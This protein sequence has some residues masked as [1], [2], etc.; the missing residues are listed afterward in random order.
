MKSLLILYTTILTTLTLIIVESTVFSKQAQQE[1]VDA[2]NT[3]RRGVSPLAADMREI[4]WSNCLATVAD[5]YI[6]ECRGLAPNYDRQEQAQNG[7]C[8]ASE[9]IVGESI[10]S[11][12]GTINSNT[13]PIQYWASENVNFIYPSTC[14][15]NCLGYVQLIWSTTTFVGCAFLDL[16]TVCGE[17]GARVICNFAEGTRSG[18]PYIE[19]IACSNCTPPWSYCNN[20]LCT[21]SPT[22]TTPTISAM[23]AT[24]LATNSA[25]APII[26]ATSEPTVETTP[27]SNAGSIQIFV[28]LVFAPIF[29]IILYLHI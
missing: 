25:T 12:D 8:S 23:S 7:N 11:I 18:T 9:N 14:N 22:P 2:I 6:N 4:Q 5:N 27:T 15:G 3:I 1:I 19:G 26:A 21:L 10:Y 28:I 16:I 17:S 20:G 29:F 13:V 24:N